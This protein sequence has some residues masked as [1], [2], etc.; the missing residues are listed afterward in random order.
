MS[1]HALQCRKLIAEEKRA[2]T[3]L[4]AAGRDKAYSAI[5][6]DNGTVIASPYSIAILLNNISKA[7]KKSPSSK[8]IRLS[9]GLKLYDVIPDEVYNGEVEDMPEI[10]ANRKLPDITDLDEDD[11]EEA[12]ITW[13]GDGDDE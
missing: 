3:L 7:G 2:G 6:L 12:D 8:Q 13:D 5:I 11:D 4:N 1:T 10:E 9:G